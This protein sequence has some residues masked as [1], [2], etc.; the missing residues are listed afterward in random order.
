MERK[1]PAQ[2][3]SA[4]R[5]YMAA[6]ENI[7]SQMEDIA[8][9]YTRLLSEGREENE[10]QLSALLSRQRALSQQHFSTVLAITRINR[11]LD[12]LPEQERLLLELVFCDGCPA[13]DV[14]EELVI[15]K[16]SYYRLRKRALQHFELAYYGSPDA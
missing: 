15:E 10:E 14:M 11:A 13:L 12:V 7:R 4:M 8:F 5:I 3:L 2:I 6:K 16:S 1:A 9:A